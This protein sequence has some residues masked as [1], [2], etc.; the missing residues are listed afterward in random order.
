MKQKTL[1][2]LFVSILILIQTDASAQQTLRNEQA[3]GQKK[4]NYDSLRI[5]LEAMFDADQ[6]IRRILVDSIGLDSPEAGKY[7]NE[8]ASI[9]MTNR[10]KIKEILEKYGW[11]EQSKIGEKAAEA[12]FYVVQ[13]TDLEFIEKYFSQFKNLAARGEASTSRCATMED[14]ILMWKGKKQIYGT[15]AYSNNLSGGKKIFI[16]PVEDPSQVN[17]LRKRAGF[18]TTVEENASRLNAEYDPNEKLPSVKE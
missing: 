10:I 16:W 5:E 17:E 7:F 3:T 6:E 11:I 2:F 4:I 9:D 14:R 18:T 12:I 13:H 1:L 8:M 15:Q